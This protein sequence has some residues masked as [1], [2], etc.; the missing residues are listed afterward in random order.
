MGIAF[1]YVI[2]GGGVAA[3]YADLEFTKKVPKASIPDH[4]D[5]AHQV[6]DLLH[7]VYV[8]DIFFAGS[9]YINLSL[10]IFCKAFLYTVK[11]NSVHPNPDVYNFVVD[12]PSASRGESKVK[13]SMQ[14]CCSKLEPM[15][16]KYCEVC[17]YFLFFNKRL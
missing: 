14:G 10:P 1:R 13:R 17:C 6:F 15:Y 5:H 7:I 8:F 2:I 9:H 12:W 16:V 3:G 11:C 4:V